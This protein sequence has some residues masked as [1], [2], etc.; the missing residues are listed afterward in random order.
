MKAELISSIV[1]FLLKAYQHVQHIF[2]ILLDYFFFIFKQNKNLDIIIDNN[3]QAKNI[4]FN[5]IFYL[6]IFSRK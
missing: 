2:Q 6:Y 5:K 3:N 4:R 1:I